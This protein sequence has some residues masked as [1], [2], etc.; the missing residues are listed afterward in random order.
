MLQ[1]GSEARQW[2]AWTGV[3]LEFQTFGKLIDGVSSKLCARSSFFPFLGARD[4]D[5]AFCYVLEFGPVPTS[6]T[7]LLCA[8]RQA[9]KVQLTVCLLPH[10]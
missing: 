6:P 4:R 2:G 9:F 1:N 8:S 3:Q 5:Q 7:P 10:I